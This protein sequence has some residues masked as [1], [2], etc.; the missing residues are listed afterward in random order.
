MKTRMH[1]N[2]KATGRDRPEALHF[3]RADSPVRHRR[4]SIA[5]GFS[6]T[7]YFTPIYP[8]A[9]TDSHTLFPGIK[10]MNLNQLRP[11]NTSTA[12]GPVI[13]MGMG[14]DLSRNANRNHNRGAPRGR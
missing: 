3:R 10:L 9:K 14:E 5:L 13:C 4:A 7:A 1:H 2:A 11:K 8:T 12:C 6:I